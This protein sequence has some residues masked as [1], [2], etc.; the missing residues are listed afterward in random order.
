M[1][2]I[3]DYERMAMLELTDKECGEL[4]ESLNAVLS[5]FLKLDKYDT[6][7][8]LPLV[9]VLDVQNAMREDESLQTLTRE[10]LLKNAPEQQDGYIRVPA[11]ID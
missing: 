6:S 4:S 1:S 11:T 8:V 9:S 10:E 5:S 3:S 2:N 7:E